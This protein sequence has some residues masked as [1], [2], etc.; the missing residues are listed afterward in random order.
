[1]EKDITA[2]RRGPRSF[3]REQALAVAMHMFWRHGYEGVSIS[4]LTGAMGIAAPSLYAAF[5]NKEALYRETLERYA[6]LSHSLDDIEAATSPIDVLDGVLRKAVAE[7]T[8]PRGETGCMIS[9]GMVQCGPAHSALGRH[10]AEQRQVVFE[11]IAHALRRWLDDKESRRLARY[12]VTL[13]QGLAIQARDGVGRSELDAIAR[14]SLANIAGLVR[15]GEKP[16][17]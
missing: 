6:S 3:D 1:M 16:G 14:L 17:G 10:L 12:A 2:A 15:T 7:V 5:G 9:L 8:D 13:L 11:T 4:D